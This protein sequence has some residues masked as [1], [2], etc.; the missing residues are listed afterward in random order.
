MVHGRKSGIVFLRGGQIVHA[1]TTAGRG[2]DA[3]ADIVSWNIIEFAYDKT[4]RPPVETISQLW[5][6]VLVE[7]VA[8][9]REAKS[10]GRRR[11]GG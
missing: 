5:D 7:V 6:E 8:E 2:R 10:S 1:E 11:F 4:V 9:H 3:L